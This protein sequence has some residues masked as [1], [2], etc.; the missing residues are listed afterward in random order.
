MRASY[1]RKHSSTLSDEMKATIM[2]KCDWTKILSGELKELRELNAVGQDTLTELSNQVPINTEREREE[3][4]R[5]VE[6]AEQISV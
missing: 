6:H 5:Q 1:V 3:Y 2:E 4:K